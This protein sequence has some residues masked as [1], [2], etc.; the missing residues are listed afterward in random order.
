M[1]DHLPFLS[2]TIENEISIRRQQAGTLNM[3]VGGECK[4]PARIE[5]EF[6]GF[7]V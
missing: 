7:G 5:R 4:N 1:V 6:A 3:D 2:R